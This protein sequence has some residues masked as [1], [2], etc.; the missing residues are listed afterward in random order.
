[1]AEKGND[2]SNAKISDEDILRI[3][4]KKGTVIPIN[5]DELKTILQKGLTYKDLYAVFEAA[6]R[7]DE[8]VPTWY[9]KEMIAVVNHM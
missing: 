7:S 4:R 9:D 1:M 2:R 3:L 5:V 6:Y 8:P